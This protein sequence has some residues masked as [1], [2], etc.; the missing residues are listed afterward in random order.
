MKKPI[1]TMLYCIAFAFVLIS[2]A[3][4][5]NLGGGKVTATSLNFRSEASTDA[6]IL[7]CASYGSPVVILEKT[8]ED[9]YSVLY[10]G[11]QGYMNSAYLETVQFSTLK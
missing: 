7:A 10:Q 11:K 6:A 5:A 2:S 3:S 4:A 1:R 9:W 8:D